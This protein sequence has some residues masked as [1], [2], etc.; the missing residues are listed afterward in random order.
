MHNLD[1]VPT[2][3]IGSSGTGVTDSCELPCGCWDSI[4]GPLEEQQVLL[5]SEPSLQILEHF[6]IPP[7]KFYTRR[8]VWWYMPL[9]PACGRQ[10]QVD[11]WE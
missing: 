2:E 8:Q 1:P 6:I 5:T 10:K 7:K 9:I 3:A 11:L 4:S